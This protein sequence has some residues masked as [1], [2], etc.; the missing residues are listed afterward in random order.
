VTKH[1]Y[2]EKIV[3][4]GTPTIMYT[5]LLLYRYD[6][7]MKHIVND[8]K[9][10]QNI[11]RTCTTALSITSHCNLGFTRLRHQIPKY[12]LQTTKI[13]FKCSSNE[14]HGSGRWFCMYPRRP[15]H[16]CRVEG[17]KGLHTFLQGLRKSDW[18]QQ[19][20]KYQQNHQMWNEWVGKD[21]MV[22]A[23]RNTRCTTCACIDMLCATP[24]PT[25]FLCILR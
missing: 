20:L 22:L 4:L 24:R 10:L 5:Q 18:L 19:H 13:T 12:L 6:Y 21:L 9:V 3:K 16:R 2:H 14:F 23:T 17:Y 15:H 7:S 8:M 25:L 1:A 11:R